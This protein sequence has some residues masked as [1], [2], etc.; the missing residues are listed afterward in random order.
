MIDLAAETHG[1]VIVPSGGYLVGTLKLHPHL[2]LVGF[3]ICAG[4]GS[5]GSVLN[6]ADANAKFCSI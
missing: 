1:T 5:N 4:K 2:G 3:P 6:L